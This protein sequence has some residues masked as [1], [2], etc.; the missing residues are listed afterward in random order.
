MLNDEY[1]CLDFL[2]FYYNV[3]IEYKPKSRSYVIPFVF[4]TTAFCSLLIMHGLLMFKKQYFYFLESVI[5]GIMI[6]LYISLLLPPKTQ[7]KQNIALYVNQ[8]KK[9]CFECV[10]RKPRRSYHCDICKVCIEQYDHHCTW[11][12]NCVGKKNIARFILFIFFLIMSLG[13]IG[14]TAAWGFLKQTFIPNFST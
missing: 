4:F 14:I 9:V 5:L 2:K 10:K 13:I 6:L 3:K 11:I 12:N 8:T 1:N 7:D